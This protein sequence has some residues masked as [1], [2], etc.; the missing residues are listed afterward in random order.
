MGGKQLV[1]LLSIVFLMQACDSEETKTAV[2]QNEYM[3][4][5]L[6]A[7]HSQVKP[8]EITYYFNEKRAAVLDSMRQFKKDNFQEYVSFSYWYIREVLNSGFTEK[9]IE[10]VDRFNAEISGA[11]QKLDQ[12][13]NYFFKRLEALS[14]IR[15]GEQQNCLINHTSA[16][17]ILPI[18]DN[19]VHQ[20]KLGSQS[21]IDIIE[22][23]L[24]DYPD[25]LELVWL[26]NICY[27]TIG[28][29]PQNVPSEYLIAPDAFEDNNSTLKAFVDLAP[30][31]GIASKGIS[32]GSIVEDLNNDGFLDIVASSSGVTEKDQLK[33]FFNNGDGTFSDQTVS[34]GVS[35]LFGGLNCMQ[36]DYNNDGFVDLFILRGGWFG[37]WGQHPNSLLKN[38]GDGT[39]TDVTEKAG[40]LS[41]HPTQTAVWRDFN[42]DGWVD[43]FIGNETTAKGVIGRAARGKVHASEFYVNQ[44]DGT[45]KNLAAEAGL[46]FEELIK[47]VTALDANNDGLDD[48]YISIMGG[49]NMLMIN[50]GN[51]KFADQA[52]TLNLTEPFVSFSTGSMDY[53]NDGFDD[54]FVSAYTTSNNPLAHEVTFELQ[55][56]SP[57]AALPKLYRNNGDGSFTDVTETTGFLKSIYGMGFNYGDLDNDGYLDLYFG[58]GDPNFES[59]IPN[60]MFRNVEG[61]FFEEVSFAGG[62]SN[63]QK[64]HGISWGDMDNDGD[65]DIYIT[66]GGAHEGDI[67]QNQLLVNP[68][69]NKSWIN[70]HLTGTI[71]NKKA[72]GA[73]VHLVTS[74]GQHLYRTVSNG[75]SFGGNSYALEIGLGDAQSIDLL[76]ITWPVA[77]SKQAFR[78]IPVNQSIEIV[79]AN[80]EIVSRSRTSLDFFKGN[81]QMNH[82]EHE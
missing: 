52:K 66:M 79:E 18:T 49:D 47:G 45:F 12:Q 27:Q 10:E 65:H 39:F 1:V 24:V 53:N 76:E 80:D 67:Y 60:R 32:G 78:N 29:Y 21:A 4:S 61:N 72:I 44:K 48:I 55:G 41:F 75:A 57:T 23:L 6:A 40:L 33:I 59:I 5:L 62:F 43:V 77:N 15:L 8:A 81:D 74:K 2:E 37:Q 13:W 46:E 69:E 58:T 20:L 51:L 26:L 19:G 3:V 9:A 38:N 70:L 63:I 14:Y 22:P 54:L 11:G 68:N 42:Q 34:S 36:T 17:C 64:G 82:S 30:N 35:G 28:E 7:R 71:S 16:S 50:Q 31:L 73:R 25:D 56:N